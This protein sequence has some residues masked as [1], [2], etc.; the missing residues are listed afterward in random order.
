MHLVHFNISLSLLTWYPCIASMPNI[1]GWSSLPG[2]EASCKLGTVPSGLRAT[3][4][5]LSTRTPSK[6]I[7]LFY[8]IYPS[9]S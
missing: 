9:P 1:E 5:L 4:Y 2:A 6:C 7:W 3:L 8:H